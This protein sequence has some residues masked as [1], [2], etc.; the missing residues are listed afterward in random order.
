[1]NFIRPMVIL[2]GLIALW[3]TIVMVSG[4]PAYI[5]PGPV[6]A[7]EAALSHAVPL[8]DNAATTVLEIIAGLL[9][10]TFWGAFNRVA[11]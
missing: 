2:F 7:A 8:L 10:G 9:I 1:M 11:R 6:K 4:V 3:Q 5:L